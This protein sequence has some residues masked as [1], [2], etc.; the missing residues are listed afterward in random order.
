ME[1]FNVPENIFYP[2]FKYFRFFIM[3]F[4]PCVLKEMWTEQQ[5]VDLI[6]LQNEYYTEDRNKC[7]PSMALQ[8]FEPW[9]IFSVS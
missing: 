6:F 2:T 1:N 7:A 8:L 3:D 5:T 4:V 9:P